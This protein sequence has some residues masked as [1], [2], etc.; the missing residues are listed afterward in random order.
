MFSPAVISFKNDV[1][2]SYKRPFF[3]PGTATRA[4]T[5]T[6]SKIT[7]PVPVLIVEQLYG[8]GGGSGSGSVSATLIEAVPYTF[9]IKRQCE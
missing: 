6:Y 2:N 4:G 9:E 8:S 1:S 3:T 7:V 5:G